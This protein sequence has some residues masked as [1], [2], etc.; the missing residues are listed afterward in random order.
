MFRYL[1]ISG[2]GCLTS[3]EFL[4]VYDATVLTWELQYS[5]IPW[6]NMSWKPLQFLCQG[7]NAVIT[8]PYFETLI[9]KHKIIL[10]LSQVRIIIL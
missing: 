1:N 2:N 8:W 10:T 7:A 5:N 4:N 3:D 9:C 6:Y